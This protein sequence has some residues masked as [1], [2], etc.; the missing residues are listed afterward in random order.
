MLDMWNSGWYPGGRIGICA[1]GCPGEV[2]S[3]FAHNQYTLCTVQK[4]RRNNSCGIKVAQTDSARMT[5]LPEGALLVG[6][7]HR[8]LDVTV[9]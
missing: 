6:R 1:A 3:Y 2:V 8:D 5:M 9:H 7:H 4:N